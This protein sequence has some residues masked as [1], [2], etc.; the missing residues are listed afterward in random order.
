MLFS[1]CKTNRN[2]V[3]I[4]NFEHEKIKQ[5]SFVF[6]LLYFQTRIASL[7]LTIFRYRL[8]SQIRNCVTHQKHDQPQSSLLQLMIITVI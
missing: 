8:K 4:S 2:G 6:F 3:R 7:S 1:E 5:F